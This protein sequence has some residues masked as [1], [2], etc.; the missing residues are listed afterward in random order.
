VLG[1]TAGPQSAEADAAGLNGS[2]LVFTHTAG[3]GSATTM[4]KDPVTD[5]QFGVAGLELT[6]SIVVIV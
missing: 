6:D 3:A 1:N 2:P 4:V 5:G